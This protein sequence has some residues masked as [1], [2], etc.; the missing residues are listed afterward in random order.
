M[1]CQTLENYHD[2]PEENRLHALY[3]R[4]RYVQAE[5]LLGAW[6]WSCAW[7]LRSLTSFECVLPTTC[8]GQQGLRN[9]WQTWNLRSCSIRDADALIPNLVQVDQPQD[10]AA[11]FLAPCSLRQARAPEDK[12]LR[13]DLFQLLVTETRGF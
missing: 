12:T 10:G 6:L 7:G 1:R 9:G 11:C 3:L 2:P 8:Q 13:E 5:G 4:Q